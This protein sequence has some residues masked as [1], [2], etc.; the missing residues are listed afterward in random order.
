MPAS[1]AEM[2]PQELQ[3]LIGTVVEEKLFELLGD[4]DHG[5]EIKMSMQN[6]LKRQQQ[7]VATGQRGE[8]LKD[9][10]KRLNLK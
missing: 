3:L 10:K 9:V 1:V 7:A 2:T 8:S 5:L 4:P 6:R